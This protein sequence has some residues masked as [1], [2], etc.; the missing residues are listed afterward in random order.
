MFDGQGG[1][2][3]PQAE[4]KDP[5]ARIETTCR[6]RSWVDTVLWPRMGTWPWAVDICP[7]IW[8]YE[9]PTARPQNSRTLPLG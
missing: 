3:R 6:W 8:R 2:K 7:D 1:D 5:H 4:V 9:F